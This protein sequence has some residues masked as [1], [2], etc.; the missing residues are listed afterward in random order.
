MQ[1][2]VTGLGREALARFVSL[3][4]RTLKLHGAANVLV[5]GNRALQMLNNRFRHQNRPTD[6]LSFPAA[7]EL[8]DGFAGDIAISVD[9]AKQNARR[10]GH[11]AAQEVKILALHGLL[12]LA[13]YDHER[14]GGEMARKEQR[15]RKMLGLQSGL[16][17]RRAFA[18]RMAKNLSRGQRASTGLP[19]GPRRRRV[20]KASRTLR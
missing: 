11:S 15:V 16:I 19:S 13:G 10:L 7:P 14:D 5:S 1:K 6:V 12:H 18:T 2:S 9:I 20:S 3:A 8:A 17:E 4:S